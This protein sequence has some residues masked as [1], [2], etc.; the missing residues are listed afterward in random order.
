MT[1]LGLILSIGWLLIQHRSRSSVKMWKI[2][3]KQ[4]EESKRLAPYFQVM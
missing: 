2:E 1:I 4:L 3:A